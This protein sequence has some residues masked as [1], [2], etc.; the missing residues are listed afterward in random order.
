MAQFFIRTLATL[1]IVGSLLPLHSCRYN[2]KYLALGSRLIEYATKANFSEANL[3]REP[4]LEFR[5]CQFPF[6]GPDMFRAL[7]TSTKRVTIRK[8][9]VRNVLINHDATVEELQVIDSGLVTLEAEIDQPNY[10]LKKVT[11]RSKEYRNWS[12]SLRFLEMLEEIDIAYCSVSYLH[13]QWFEKYDKLKALDVSHNKLSRLDVGFSKLL[14]LERMHLWGNRLEQLYRFPEAFPALKMVTLAQ[15]RWRCQWVSVVRGAMLARGVELLDM[16]SVCL[17]GWENNGGLCC[18]R[19]NF[20]NLTSLNR[21][22]Q[23][24]RNITQ[25]LNHI[26]GTDG[27]VIGMQLGNTTVFLDKHFAI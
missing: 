9:K 27:S 11:I 15:N 10:V 4:H 24:D 13:M 16:D 8:G 18:R 25:Q 14:P 3:P 7:D 1:L 12:A 2:R 5:M 17:A 26:M 22:H 23:D 20:V 21:A 19:G 6:F